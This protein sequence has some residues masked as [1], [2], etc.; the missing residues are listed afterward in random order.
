MSR[1]SFSSLR[2]RLLLLVLL[3]V[4]PAFGLMLYTASNDRANAASDATADAL[5][6]ARNAARD[7]AQ[8]IEQARQV[9]VDLSQLPS[10]QHD[11]APTCSRMFNDLRANTCKPIRVTPTW[12]PSTATGT[13]FAAC[14]P[15]AARPTSPRRGI[16]SKPF[17]RTSSRSAMPLWIARSAKPSSISS[18]PS[19]TLAAGCG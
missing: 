15:S 6:V 7:Q 3:A 16:F 5:R 19:S 9:L 17:G 12:A 13:S 14:C 4:I 10:T 1:L 18:T 8:L 2:I 11:E